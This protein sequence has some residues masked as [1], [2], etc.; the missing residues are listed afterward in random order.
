MIDARSLGILAAM[1]LLPGLLFLIWVR[2]QERHDR[3]PFGAVLR[4]FL[5]G[6][7][8]GVIV[9]VL[10]HIVFDIGIAQPNG[11]F[12][13]S[14]AFVGAVV[15][16][17]VVEELAKGIGLG[18]VRRHIAELEDGIV[19]GAAIGLGFGATENLVYGLTAYLESGEM[20]AVATIVVR[21]FSSLLL[22]AGASALLGFGYA[23]LIL[24]GNVIVHLLPYYMLAVLLHAAYN[25]VS[26]VGSTLGLAAAVF[27][28]LTVFGKLRAKIR[29]LDALPH[30]RELLAGPP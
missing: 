25:F 18:G 1:S 7:T 3:E 5:Y 10:L 13:L 22:H 15:A 26:F 23:R 16:A 21:V 29:Q 20:V 27:I 30:E 6:G 14:A 24:G 11:N 2:R 9:A 8:F 12:G 19:Y 28:G 4:A 17:P